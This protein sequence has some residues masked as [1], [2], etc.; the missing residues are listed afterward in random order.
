MNKANNAGIGK[1]R[2]AKLCLENVYLIRYLEVLGFNDLENIYATEYVN[3][4]INIF[5]Q[6][7]LL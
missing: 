2:L 6:I 3:I 5:Y 4:F 7:F 1:N